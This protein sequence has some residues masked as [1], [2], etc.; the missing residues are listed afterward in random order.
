MG[1]SKRQQRWWR[2]TSAGLAFL[3]ALCL[4]SP[5]AGAA[6]ADSGQVQ[7]QL[8][9]RMNGYPLN[10]VAAFV[11]MPD[12]K[13]GSP[14]SELA[15]LGVAVP[16]T[17]APEEVIVLDSLPGVSY[18][19][20]EA[21][22]SIEIELPNAT[23]LA[24]TLDAS[25]GGT[26]EIT[27]AESSNGLVINYTAFASADYKI[28]DSRAA[29]DGGS[30]SL[31]ARAFSKF[32]TLRQT[33]ILGTTTFSDFTALRLDTNWTYSDPDSMR[34]YRLGD[35]VSGGL[36]WTRPVRLGGAQVQRN[37]SLRPDLI[38][39]PLPQLAGSAEVP[40]TLQVF[41]DG[42]QA[43]ASDVQPGPFRLDSLPVYTTSGTARMVLTD[44]TGREIDTEQQFYTSPDLLKKNL[45]DFSLEG[46]VVRRDFGTAAFGYDTSPV[47]LASARYGVSDIFT[48][49]A[50]GE[51][52][53][54]LADVGAGGLLLA[55]RFG[56]FSAAAAGSLY[57]GDM[58]AFVHAG[59]EDHI[60]DFGVNVTSSRTIGK[61]FDL[62]AATA[63]PADGVSQ[64]G[65]PKALDQISLTY[66]FR[67]LKSGVGLSFINQLASDNKRSL[68][69]SGS[70]SQSFGNSLTAFVTGFA[71]F[72][73]TRGLGAFVGF[74]MPF[75]EDI[76]T[77]AGMSVS[78][79]G[80]TAD[81]EA[82]RTSDGTPGSYGWRVSHGE[83]DQ[84]Y[85]TASGTYHSSKGTVQGHLTQQDQSFSGN[86]AFDGSAV[87]AGGGL[88]LGNQIYD[89]FA[90]VDAGAPNVSVEYE[91]RFAGKTDSGGRLLLP[92][93]RSFQNNKISIDV[94]DLPLTAVIPE[95]ETIVVPRDMSG[96]VV[97]FG[98]K[99][100]AP[101][102]LVILTDAKG[103]YLPESS[104]V[105]LEGL[106]DPFLMGYDGQV[107]ITGL[108]AENKV[109]VKLRGNQC[110]AS[111]SY[112]PDNQN[113]TTIGP[114]QCL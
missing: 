68:I 29:A 2:R 81:A 60:G 65:V 6:A 59:W 21:G 71:D 64:G 113:Q 101:A 87:L 25:R 3:L 110:Q 37:F 38:T 27:K 73:D 45:Y 32:G 91:N 43:Y 90:V 92:D 49:E 26:T 93:L 98:V 56:M 75:G 17:G 76:S 41:I 46:G 40:S 86:A 105:T 107:Y 36:S 52:S 109:T 33:A 108:A 96:G 13:I 28:P 102:A 103:N 19:Y 34:T 83:G 112:K 104:E 57:K 88:F 42:T 20:D 77:S 47:G 106:A 53:A 79:S 18:V 11:R 69:V 9:V 5:L 74:S 66:A 67:Q 4:A 48:A 95:S 70:Y 94:T 85:T 15:E 16:G 61:Y 31:D 114:L 62:A 35:I 89:S 54:D 1:Q 30:L 100:E 58:G 80:W 55:G 12:G 50:H 72:G 24:R 8:D 39:M 7:L 23:R 99:A 44:S 63:L 14:R 84:S 78:N 97:D 22:Q 10:L 51:G 82:S 111:F